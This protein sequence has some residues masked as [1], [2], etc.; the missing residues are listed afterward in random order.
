MTGNLG[1]PVVLYDGTCGFC[2]RAAEVALAVLPHRVDWEPSQTV[3]LEALGVSEAEAADS[4]R[5]VEPSGRVS[6]GSAALARLLVLSGPPWTLVGTVLMSP[7][8][9]VLGRAVYRIVAAVRHRL[10][11]STPALDRWPGDRPRAR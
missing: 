2:T 7:P 3:N 5:L 1:R 10:P 9:S 11:G 6:H 8:V 4:V